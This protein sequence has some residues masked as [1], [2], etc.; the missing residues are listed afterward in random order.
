[1]KDLHRIVVPKVSA[2]WV[3]IAY[4]LDYD[5]PAVRVIRSENNENPIKCCRNLF[6]DWLITSNGVKPKTWG[7]LL[8][9]LKEIQELDGVTKEIIEKL[10]Q[11][12]LQ[13]CMLLYTCR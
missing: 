7:T 6:E 1:M 2:D 8:D 5:I 9:K 10:I 13:D 4:A 12:D 11:K 3:D